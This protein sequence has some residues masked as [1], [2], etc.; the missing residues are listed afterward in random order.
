MVGS[1]SPPLRDALV[2]LA[3]ADLSLML[4]GVHDLEVDLEDLA[5]LG[6]RALELSPR[7]VKGVAADPALRDAVVDLTERAHRADLLI[8]ANGISNER[9]HE[10]ILQ[11][12]C[13]TAT[14]DLY[15]P[16]QLTEVMGDE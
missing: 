10:A 12:R 4:T 2:S 9:Q 14:G 15:A 16:A 3:D 6:F 13:D 5:R 1:A 7:L 8:G 11:L